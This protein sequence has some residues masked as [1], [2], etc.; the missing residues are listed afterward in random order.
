MASVFSEGVLRFRSDGVLASERSTL[1]GTAAAG[2]YVGG[3]APPA[4]YELNGYTLTLIA[5]DG[6]RE[7]RSYAAP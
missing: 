4:R 5:P 6:T 3:A 1:A 2:A 7:R